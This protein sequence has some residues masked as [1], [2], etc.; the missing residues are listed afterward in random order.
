MAYRYLSDNLHSI[1][2][3]VKQYFRAERGL[4][5]FRIEEEVHKGLD[6]RPTLHTFSK[7]HHIVCIDVQDSPYSASLDSVVLDCVKES[8]PIRL[9]VA[10]PGEPPPQEYKKKVD[11]ARKNGVGVIEVRKDMI[12]VTHE[13]LA[14]SLLGVRTVNP[15][16]FPSRFRGELVRAE[17]TF[18]S[19]SPVEG[20]LIIYKE[21]EALSREIVNKTRKK[22]LWRALNPG[23]GSPHIKQ[24]TP[25][26]RII[27]ILMEHLDRQ[28]CPALSI[29]L[30]ARV[31]SVA[32]HRNDT[33]HKITSLN[34]LIKRDTELKTRFESAT[35]LL[36]ELIAAHK[37]I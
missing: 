11:R 13:A 31:L 10:Y 9:Y 15:K 34:Q 7:D 25:W 5:N 23:E 21:L 3:R 35:D 33:G 2:D 24:N 22:G 26:Q 20:S 16:R 8:L 29:P 32:P 1:A 17:S 4:S 30:L 19:G 6:Y 12:E 14:L 28:A 37:T 18:R 36:L 27:Q